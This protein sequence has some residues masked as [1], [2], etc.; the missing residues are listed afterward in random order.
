[1]DGIT[2]HTH[3]KEELKSIR[4]RIRGERKKI[5]HRIIVHR[6]RCSAR[7]AFVCLKN[8]A[9]YRIHVEKCC[10]SI[11]SITNNRT[12]R[13]KRAEWKWMPCN[14]NKQKQNWWIFFVLSRHCRRRRSNKREKKQCS[15]LIPLFLL[16]FPSILISNLI[17]YF[18]RWLFWNERKKSSDGISVWWCSLFASKIQ[19]DL[20]FGC[21]HILFG[22]VKSEKKKTVSNAFI[23]KREKRSISLVLLISSMK[24]RR[25]KAKK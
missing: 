14:A 3:K 12:S 24:D 2:A 8:A 22:F 13:K 21:T 1:M 7:N 18:L 4:Q 11:L 20:F 23:E 15:C 17:F 16:R 10:T 19:V 6:L 25:E 5:A 9:V